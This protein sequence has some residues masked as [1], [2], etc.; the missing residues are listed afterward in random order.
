M[1]QVEKYHANSLNKLI[2]AY[3][4][5]YF[6][7]LVDLKH[8]LTRISRSMDWVAMRVDYG[9]VSTQRRISWPALLSTGVGLP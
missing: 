2:R 6:N 9:G 7:A 5:N 4:S 1:I 3:L 8:V